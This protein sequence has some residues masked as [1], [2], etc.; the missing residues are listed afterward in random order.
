MKGTEK[1]GYALLAILALASLFGLL[2]SSPIE[3]NLEYHDFSDSNT[4]F[5]V[6]NFWNVLSNLPFLFIG[7]YGIV[8][9]NLARINCLQY[10]IFFLSI[11]L[12]SIGSGYYHLNPNNATL[13]WDRLPMTLGFMSI[14]SIIISEFINHKAGKRLL[15]PLL[16]LGL[17]SILV[18]K[19][20]RDLRLYI[21]IQFFPT[22]A[23][24]II[25]LFFKPTNKLTFGYWA[26]LLSYII[27]KI[28]EY[29]DGVVYS[30]LIFISGHT[31]KH[32]VIAF[33]MIILL[34]SYIK[35]QREETR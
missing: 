19:F 35:I 15:F 32:L 3:Q 25:L 30:Y 31:L 5:G 33:G 9:L 23:I 28:L 21:L 24:P 7:I 22:F 11:A 1:I 34:F 10:F 13:V 8:R 27:A 16:F 6:L 26:L 2:F 12:V 14:F 4:F 20:T 17:L 18:W 29:Y